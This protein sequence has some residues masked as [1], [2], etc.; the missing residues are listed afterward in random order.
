MGKA[1]ERPIGLLGVH[2]CDEGEISV[3]R[4]CSSF[5]G[6]L[7]AFGLSGSSVKVISNLGGG[8]GGATA[9]NGGAKVPGAYCSETGRLD[10][11]EEGGVE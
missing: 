7:I 5:I 2:F 6:C 3:L 10:P 11:R 1:R 4:R 9:A 8:T